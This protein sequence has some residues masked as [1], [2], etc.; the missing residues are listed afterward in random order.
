MNQI[1]TV[2]MVP[3]SQVV[4]GDVPV[5]M[6]PATWSDQRPHDLSAECWCQPTV[7]TVIAR[8]VHKEEKA[9]S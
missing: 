6:L 4:S 1:V 8:I 2:N 5:Q 3:D 9:E 7:E